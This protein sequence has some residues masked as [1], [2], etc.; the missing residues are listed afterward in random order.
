MTITKDD[1][2][3]HLP[4]YYQGNDLFEGLAEILATE[5]AIGE[6]AVDEVAKQGFVGTATLVGLAL[7]EEEFRIPTDLSLSIAERRARIRARIVGLDTTTP[8]KSK[9]IAE[10][11]LVGENCSI[12]EDFAAYQV[13]IKFEVVHGFPPEEAAIRAA[14]EE[15]LPAHIELLFD[16]EFNLWSEVLSLGTWADALAWGDW[17]DI[18]GTEI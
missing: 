18:L 13:T 6:T 3:R 15:V 10:G 17:V 8:T 4:R 1:L 14:V 16:Y 12:I 9:A 5:L 2:L 11:I 7:W